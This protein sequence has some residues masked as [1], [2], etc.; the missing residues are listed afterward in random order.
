MTR[1]LLV[2]KIYGYDRSVLEPWAKQL[3]D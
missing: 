2:V 3:N 1:Q